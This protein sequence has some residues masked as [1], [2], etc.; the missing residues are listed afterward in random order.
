MNIKQI[1]IAYCNVFGFY[2]A[3]QKIYIQIDVFIDF[4]KKKDMNYDFIK[5][6]ENRCIEFTVYTDF[7]PYVRKIL[8]Y[9]CG[10]LLLLKKKKKIVLINEFSKISLKSRTFPKFIFLVLILFV[11]SLTPFIKNLKQRTSLKTSTNLVYLYLIA[12]SQFISIHI[13]LFNKILI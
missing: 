10:L 1:N 5:S 11:K 3:K 13:D 8:L 12:I 4:L 2:D 9:A 6:I 7:G